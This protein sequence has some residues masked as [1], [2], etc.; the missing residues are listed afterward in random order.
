MS[1]HGMDMYLFLFVVAPGALGVEVIARQRARMRPRALT[2]SSHRLGHGSVRMFIPARILVARDSVPD[3]EDGEHPTHVDP[4]ERARSTHHANAVSRSAHVHHLSHSAL[5][6]EHRA[7]D[8][9]AN[10]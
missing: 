6:H 8:Y 9:A 4:P 1:A 5:S 3:L 7:G 10:I 2:R